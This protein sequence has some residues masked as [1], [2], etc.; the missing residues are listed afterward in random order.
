MEISGLLAFGIFPTFV[1]AICLAV[2]WLPMGVIIGTIDALMIRT[3]S[4]IAFFIMA[5]LFY[6][7]VCAQIRFKIGRACRV[8][9]RPK[10]TQY[11]LLVFLTCLLQLVVFLSKGLFAFCQGESFAFISS[12]YSSLDNLDVSAKV[13]ADVG[14]VI[15]LSNQRYKFADQGWLDESSGSDALTDMVWSGADARLAATE[16]AT[17][18]FECLA[19]VM[20]PVMARSLRA[21]LQIPNGA[22]Q[23]LLIVPW[24]V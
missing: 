15:G 11:N 13:V 14:T 23:R 20:A 18:H 7:N 10:Y 17:Q 1:A 24:Y 9:V 22:A 6:T 3:R 21:V 8:V 16:I 19:P 4:K 5:V 12:R 2:A